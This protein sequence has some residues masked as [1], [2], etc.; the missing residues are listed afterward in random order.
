MNRYFGKIL[1]GF[2]YFIVEMRVLF[3]LSVLFHCLSFLLGIIEI[4]K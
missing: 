1:I 4:S 3:T 2:E